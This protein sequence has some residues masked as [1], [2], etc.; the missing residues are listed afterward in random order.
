[1]EQAPILADPRLRSPDPAICPFLRSLVDGALAMPREG[2]DPSNA[3]VAIGT[4]EPQSAEQQ[5][6]ACLVAAHVACVRYLTGS[7]APTAD[8]AAAGPARP[9]DPATSRSPAPVDSMAGA[10]RPRRPRRLVTPAILGASAFLVASALLAMG[11]VAARGGLALPTGAAA[12]ASTGPSPSATLAAGPTA[13]PD[14]G[15]AEPSAGPTA[16]PTRT[17]RP[18]ATPEATS[19]RYALL[20]PCSATP[21]CYVYVVRQGDNLMS[22]ANWFGVPYATVLAMNSWIVDPSVIHA[23]ELLRLPPP[24]R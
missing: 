7:A 15:T 17:P 1:M 16:A 6:A 24:T 20:E 13:T 19:D 8:V 9:A 23:G 12:V 21:D 11:F 14:L 10:R 5:A 3:C 4:L 18:T 22:I 2:V